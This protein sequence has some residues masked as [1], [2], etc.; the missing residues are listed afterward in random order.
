MPCV[1]KDSHLQIIAYIQNDNIFMFCNM[2]TKEHLTYLNAANG[3]QNEY[4][5]VN[6]QV[7]D[8]SDQIQYRISFPL[9]YCSC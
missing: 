2:K 9:W 1:N 3:R 5:V 4:F 8:I 7:L 6:Y